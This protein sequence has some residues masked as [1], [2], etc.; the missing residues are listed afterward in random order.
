MNETVLRD[1]RRQCHRRQ[2]RVAAGA[3]LFGACGA[4][5][6]APDGEDV[7]TVSPNAMHALTAPDVVARV[8]D[9]QPMGDGRIW[10][11]N[12]TAPYFILLGPDGRVERQFGEPGGGPGEFGAPVAFVLGPEPGEVWTYD[13]PRSALIRVSDEGRRELPLPLDSL[14]P[15][16]LI[17]FQGAGIRPA[18]PWLRS[19][20]EGFLLA[21]VRPS[22]ARPA[23]AL[24]LWQADI[25]LLR[26]DAPGV[27]LAV[28][29]PIADFL[30]D[31]APRYRAATAMLPYPLWTV[32]ADGTVGLYDPLAN[33]LRRFTRKGQELAPFPEYA[34]LRCTSDGMLWLRPFDVTTGRLG[35]G[36]DWHRFSADGSRTL[37]KLPREFRTFR[38]DADRIWGTVQDPLGFDSIVWIRLDSLR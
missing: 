28:H 33:T 31:P 34:D 10:L 27:E 29:T 19:N 13:V 1:R 7:V 25:L 35:Q 5:G 18:P 16:S 24:R 14:P 21:R 3:L 12:S 9:L 8:V 4:C 32:C 6:P 26:G 2:W 11:L 37:V 38:I 15:S 20:R 36:S 23:S 22:A 30:G 17:S